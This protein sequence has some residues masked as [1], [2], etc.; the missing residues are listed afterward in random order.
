[1]S[2]PWTTCLKYPTAFPTSALKESRPRAY[3]PFAID[4]HVC[5]VRNNW[6]VREGGGE[7]GIVSYKWE[8]GKDR[9]EG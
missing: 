5:I 4:G 2:R 7:G 8:H 3:L 6:G 9:R 1:M